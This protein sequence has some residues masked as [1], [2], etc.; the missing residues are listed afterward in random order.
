VFGVSGCKQA[1]KPGAAAAAM[2]MPV[3]PVSAAKAT[4]ESVPTELRVVGTVEASAI[5]QVKSQIAGELLKMGFT[6]GQNVVEDQVL[7]EVDPRP[8]EE[9]LRQAEANVT[10]DRAQIGQFEATLARDAAQ[11]QFNKTDADRYAELLKAGVVSKSQSDQARTSADVA[12]ESERATKASLDSAKAALESDLAMVAAAKLN[13]NYCKITAPLAGRTGNLLVHPGNLVKV[14]DVPL[15][16]IHR[17]SPVFVNFNVP[18]QH[19][20][21]VR[22]LSENRKLAVRAFSQDEPDRIATGV[23][24]VI[25]NAVDTA[26]GTIHLKATFE[27]KDGMLWPGQFVTAVLTL[28]TISG[29]TVVPAEA[30]QAGQQGQYMYVIKPDHTVEMRIVKVGRS[31]GKRM[32]IENGV[33]PGETVVTD[34]HL[35][36]FPGAQVTLVDVGKAE[37]GKS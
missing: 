29:A 37:A 30:V 12:R 26:T 31:F 33:T 22:R 3:V 6:E 8:Y 17:V 2:G 32:V 34:G 7:F 14:N 36:L 24:T 20:A 13:L 4:R 1:A 35:R 28:D 27:N 11:A 18:E 15:V 5:V 25:D 23:L 16:V 19:L 21:A 10:R 9:A